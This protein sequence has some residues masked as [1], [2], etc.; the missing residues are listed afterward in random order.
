MSTDI[1]VSIVF[2][3]EGAFAIPAL[4][5]M[6]RLVTVAR[7]AG[8]CVEAKAMLDKPDEQTTAI[9]EQCGSWL[10]KIELVYYGDL[11][12]TRNAG[13]RSAKGEYIA[14]LDGDDLWG[15]LWLTLA[16]EAACRE[17]SDARSIWHPESLFYFYE[18]DFDAHSIGCNAN[19]DAKS[20]HFLHQASDGPDFERNVLFL[21]NIWSA[22]CFAHQTIYQKFPYK[23]VE[24]SKGFG[25]EDWSW[26]IETLW[27]GV[28]HKVCPD[29]VHI[30]RVKEAGS[31]GQG[32]I[33]H[34]LLPY[35][36]PN[37]FP[38]IGKAERIKE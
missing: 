25:V 18:S 28:E 27:A 30:I 33:T 15:S 35:L 29:T 22:N 26:N 36:P 11:G 21:N 12:L 31:L 5:S 1:T 8:I 34:G 3:S 16:Y 19:P 32:N 13:V 38:I 6:H 7:S 2:H 17:K 9:V 23:K 24:K 4:S 37:A 10:D 20:F 14:F